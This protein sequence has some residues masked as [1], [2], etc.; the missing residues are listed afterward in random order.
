MYIV[1]CTKA[2]T[3]TVINM[4]FNDFLT[5]KNTGIREHKQNID[6]I[7]SYHF[8]IW[9]LTELGED[10]NEHRQLEVSALAVVTRV[11]HSTNPRHPTPATMKQ[12]NFTVTMAVSILHV[13]FI[14]LTSTFLLYTILSHKLNNLQHNTQKFSQFIISIFRCAAGRA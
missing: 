7:E 14:L 12:Y 10:K 1:G 8:G 6:N 3:Q 9:H 4:K 5:E 2:M 13:I 11:W